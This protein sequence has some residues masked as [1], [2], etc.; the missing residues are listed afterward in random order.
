MIEAMRLK[1]SHQSPFEWHHLPTRFYE[2][3]PSSSKDILGAFI[4]EASHSFRSFFPTVN[5]LVA[6]VHKQSKPI[7]LPWL[8]L[9][10]RAHLTDLNLDNFKTIEAMELKVI[11]S[12]P[13]NGI[14]SVPNF[15]KMYHAVYKLLV[16]G[17]QADW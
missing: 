3:L 6:M 4:P 13:L 15:M 16:W 17:T 12:I 8:P 14:I 10:S 7:W 2:N 1:L 11:A 5:N 9:L